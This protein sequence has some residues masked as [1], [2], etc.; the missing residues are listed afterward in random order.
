[1]GVVWAQPYLWGCTGAML[2]VADVG[3][4]KGATSGTEG[5]CGFESQ[6]LWVQWV[7]AVAVVQA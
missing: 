7:E 3:A 6:T 4:G 2:G 5:V 1:M